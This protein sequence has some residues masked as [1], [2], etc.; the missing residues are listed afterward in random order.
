MNFFNILSL[1]G[2]LALFLYGM[3][4]MTNSLSNVSGSQMKA[5][6]KNLT[7]NKLKGVALGAGITALIQSSSG[8]TVI[9][10]G[11]VNSGIMTLKQA[12]SVIM[13][14]MSVLQ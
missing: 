1:I 3:D 10:V 14:P 9:V 11:L 6:M 2:G 7:S 12:V 8:T 4:T 13:G 5:I